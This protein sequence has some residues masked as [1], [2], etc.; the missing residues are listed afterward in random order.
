VIAGYYHYQEQPNATDVKMDLFFG[1]FEGEHFLSPA[2]SSTNKFRR[3]LNPNSGYHLVNYF[4]EPMFAPR[5]M[6]LYLR[7]H[8]GNGY[9]E[10]LSGGLFSK[11]VG[12]TVTHDRIQLRGGLTSFELMCTARSSGCDSPDAAEV[13]VSKMLQ[14]VGRRAREEGLSYWA[15]CE[16]ATRAT[17][18]LSAAPVYG[19]IVV[20]QSERARWLMV[21]RR[22]SEHSTFRVVVEDDGSVVHLQYSEYNSVRLV[23]WSGDVEPTVKTVAGAYGRY[24]AS[25]PVMVSGS[26]LDAAGL[27]SRC[28][29]C[30]AARLEA[31][32]QGQL[33]NEHTGACLR[34]AG[35]SSGVGLE[36]CGDALVWLMC[37]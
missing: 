8:Y 32:S 10:G 33:K 12:E 36:D 26:H 15:A 16:T 9:L 20:P 31:W 1:I 7:T 11:E 37:G 4:G 3:G 14:Y 13:L 27:C 34:R 29:K 2:W 5:D 35:S 22:S 25:V 21:L 28:T 17:G 18:R 24:N 30:P 6:D 19:S 23:V